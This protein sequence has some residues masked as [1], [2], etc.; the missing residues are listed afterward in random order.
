MSICKLCKCKNVKE[1][2]EKKKGY[3]CSELV[4]SILKIMKVLADNKLSSRFYPGTFEAPSESLEFIN[5]AYLDDEKLIDFYL[6]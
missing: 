5:G 2:P 3:F 4:A 6:S 1:E